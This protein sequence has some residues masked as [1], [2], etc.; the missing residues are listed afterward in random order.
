[1][2]LFNSAA[3]ATNVEENQSIKKLDKVTP[4]EQ[5]KNPAEMTD[6]EHAIE[7]YFHKFGFSKN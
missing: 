4:I 6:V 1:M 7:Y 2:R 3:G 5:V